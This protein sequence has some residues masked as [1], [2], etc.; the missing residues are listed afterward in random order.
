ME[1]LDAEI[2]P[3]NAIEL[4]LIDE[5]LQ[6]NCMAASLQEYREKAKDVASL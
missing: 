4:D 3:I 2:C 6:A 5:L 1:L